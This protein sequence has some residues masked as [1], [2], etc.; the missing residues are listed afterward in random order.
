MKL[1]IQVKPTNGKKP[2]K[3]YSTCRKLPIVFG[4]KES[5]HVLSECLCSCKV[6]YHISVK[7]VCQMIFLWPFNDFPPK[8]HSALTTTA[9]VFFFFLRSQA[10]ILEACHRS[11]EIR[12]ITWFIFSVSSCHI[13]LKATSAFLNITFHISSELPWGCYVIMPT[14]ESDLRENHFP[15]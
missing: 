3:R 4:E 12:L 8:A 1:L 14:K 15:I 2:S 7:N 6:S 10:M 5:V 13:T 11:S 9:I